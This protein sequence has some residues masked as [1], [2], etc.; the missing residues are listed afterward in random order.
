MSPAFI[1]AIVFASVAVLL[2]AS[3]IALWL[4][5]ERAW[6]ALAGFFGNVAI[7]GAVIAAIVGVIQLFLA[8]LA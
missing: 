8:V 6:F 1:V 2:W 3:A 5:V 4:T 7:S